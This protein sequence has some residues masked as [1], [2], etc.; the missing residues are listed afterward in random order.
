MYLFK[1]LLVSLTTVVFV[2]AVKEVNV[3]QHVSETPKISSTLL[4]SDLKPNSLDKSELK[5]SLLPIPDKLSSISKLEVKKDSSRLKKS[6][7]KPA[8]LSAPADRLTTVI[9][10]KNS[11]DDAS[12]LK[13]SP[14]K[15][16]TTP[17]KLSTVLTSENS[18]D[19]TY[20]SKKSPYRRARFEQFPQ[21]PQQMQY[22]HTP[23]QTTTVCIVVRSSGHNQPV[24]VCGPQTN[25]TETDQTTL[26]ETN[27]LPPARQSNQQITSI[28]V[29]PVSSG[30]RT[31]QVSSDMN[32]QQGQSSGIHMEA[33]PT[34]SDMH[35]MPKSSS[36][37]IQQPTKFL[38]EAIK[39]PG[40]IPSMRSALFQQEMF[41]MP[42]DSQQKPGN[43]QYQMV[44]PSVSGISQPSSLPQKQYLVSPYPFNQ[45][46]SSYS[47][48]TGN[49]ITS[50]VPLSL[51]CHLQPHALTNR[52]A[53]M[54]HYQTSGQLGHS[55]DVQSQEL[56][57]KPGDARTT[58][59]QTYLGR[60]IPPQLFLVP[61]TQR[62]AGPMYMLPDGSPIEG[63][64]LSLGS[65]YMDDQHFVRAS[66]DPVKPVQYSSVNPHS[67]TIVRQQ[68]ENPNHIMFDPQNIQESMVSQAMPPMA[69]VQWQQPMGRN[70]LDT[71]VQWTGQ[72]QPQV[73]SWGEQLTRSSPEYITEEYLRQWDDA[74]HQQIGRSSEG[75]MDAPSV[76][77]IPFYFHLGENQFKSDD[78]S[79][80]KPTNSEK[81]L[82]EEDLKKKSMLQ[83]QEI[84]ES[85]KKLEEMR[86]LLKASEDKLAKATSETKKKLDE[87][88]SVEI[89]KTEESRTTDTPVTKMETQKIQDK[90]QIKK[91]YKP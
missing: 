20:R 24:T 85:R 7:T 66:Q 31:Q 42:L 64:N 40:N 33:V 5:S 39:S 47:S 46:P 65:V 82:T 57:H 38:N 27:H 68:N 67:E 35:V 69:E 53:S 12:Q 8:S 23:A 14:E 19:D 60:E 86:T 63:S 25:G 26:P 83:E 37:S 76:S 4:E 52:P 56:Y 79:N 22:I 29:Q 32:M 43:F 55:S 51:N 91:L 58:F 81:P 36:A 11:E 70:S 77:Y 48:D 59:G 30:K 45:N 80:L 71:P 17:D 3:E 89:P 21:N 88:R 49:V 13:K 34:R 61:D 44:Q 90:R 62:S 74:Y 9:T 75:P 78:D 41:R 16:S 54:G 15:L 6:P 50:N 73:Q 87:E 18:E 10:S 1:V 28:P 72:E 2:C 84:K